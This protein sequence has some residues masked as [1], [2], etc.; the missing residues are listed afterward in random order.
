MPTMPKDYARTYHLAR[1]HRR[2]TDALDLLGGRCVR[3]G[4]TADLQID[5]I[6]PA[7]KSIEISK[8]WGVSKDRFW[9]EIE[10]C[11][12]LCRLHHTEKTTSEQMTRKHGTWAWAGKRKCPCTE[13][14]TFLRNYHRDYYRTRILAPI[15]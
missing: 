8:L 13:C 15:G 2:R 3:C 12:I 14:R 9:A 7:T 11:Q 5:H 10:K 6:D 4:E 1:Y